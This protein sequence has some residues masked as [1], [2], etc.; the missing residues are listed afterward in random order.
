MTKAIHCML[1]LDF[2]IDMEMIVKNRFKF[3]CINCKKKKNCCRSMR[4]NATQRCIAAIVKALQNFSYKQHFALIEM[5]YNKNEN[6][7]FLIAVLLVNAFFSQSIYRPR[8]VFFFV[9]T[10]ILWIKYDHH[11]IIKPN[12]LK[13]HRG[14]EQLQETSNREK[15]PHI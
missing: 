15:K 6:N 9:E 7:S 2:V 13:C 14:I 3:I 12:Q 4:L 10:L 11:T 1:P 5:D 8:V